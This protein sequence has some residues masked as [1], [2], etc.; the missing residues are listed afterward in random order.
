MPFK[1]PGTKCSCKQPKR[2][3]V[4][5]IQLRFYIHFKSTLFRIYIYIFLCY[6][7]ADFPCEDTD[8][9]DKFWSSYK[10]SEGR[11]NN[12]LCVQH[13]AVMHAVI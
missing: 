12:S 5:T 2:A 7:H 6:S 9:A 1:K 13:I 8:S 10:R 3:L 4:D 11:Q